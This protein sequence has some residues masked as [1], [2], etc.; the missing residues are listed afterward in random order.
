[1]CFNKDNIL[2]RIIIYC[3]LILFI[4]LPKLSGQVLDLSPRISFPVSSI[5]IQDVSD[6]PAKLINIE[7]NSIATSYIPSTFGLNELSNH[8]LNASYKHDSLFHFI[9]VSGIFQE[10]Y[11]YSNFGY[12]IGYK[13]FDKFTPTIS[14]NYN[15]LNVRDYNSF[16]NLTFDFG[17]ILELDPNFNFGFAITNLF[18]SSLEDNNDIK[19]QKALFGIE[20]KLYENFR[21]QIGTEIRIENSSSVILSFIKEFEEFGVIALSYSTE[22]QMIQLNLNM[23]TIDDFFLIYDLNYHNYLGVTNSFGIGYS[24]D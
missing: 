5:S 6:N 21:F 13:A 1:M 20:Y 4:T 24:F 11:T 16:G 10:L 7:R 8:N 22:P 3:C 2:T 19:K 12:S 14:L 23:N 18:N 17:G 9:N 15:Y